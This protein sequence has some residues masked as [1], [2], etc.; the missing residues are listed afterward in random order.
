M[1]ESSSTPGVP[2]VFLDRDGTLNEMV[3][4]STHGLMDSPRRPEQ[5]VP[6]RFAGEL[7]HGLRE[8]GYRIVVVTNQPG[9]AKGT[10]TQAELGDV[11]V[12]LAKAIPPGYWDALEY[13]PHHPEHGAGAKCA[14][15]KPAPGMLLKAAGEGGIDLSKSWM[16]GDG[17]V[18]VQAGKAAGCRTILLT[19]LKVNVV[20]RFFELDG[21]EPDF[22][23]GNL[24]E[25]LERIRGIGIQ[26]KA[27]E[28][29]ALSRQK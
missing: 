4:D 25:V 26:R 22:V 21:A 13:C 8:L 11:H 2:A 1:G 10:L 20:E 12:A 24:R 28:Q 29:G 5:V 3:Y 17:L 18:D 7:V 14:C 27:K 23:A 6:M 15:R 19:K 9:I 16:V